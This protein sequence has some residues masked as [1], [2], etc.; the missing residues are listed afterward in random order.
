VQGAPSVSPQIP[1]LEREATNK[2]ARND[3][4]VWVRSEHANNNF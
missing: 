3:I 1:Q 2:K 4:R